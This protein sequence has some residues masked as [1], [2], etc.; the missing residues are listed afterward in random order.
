MEKKIFA[1]NVVKV[2]GSRLEGAE[3]AGYEVTMN[4]NGKK[5]I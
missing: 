5:N 1:E 3:V 2:E 4:K